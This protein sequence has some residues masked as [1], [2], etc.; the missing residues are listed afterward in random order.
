ML[1]LLCLY[2]CA[3][4]QEVSQRV[5]CEPYGRGP[6]RSVD[7]KLR[8]MLTHALMSPVRNNWVA[9]RCA[10]FSKLQLSRN[11]DGFCPCF[12]S[13]V[14]WRCFSQAQTPISGQRI[15]TQLPPCCLH[16]GVPHKRIGDVIIP[17]FLPTD[18]LF[19]LCKAQLEVVT[20][21]Q[22]GV[23]EVQICQI[24][25]VA[26]CLPGLLLCNKLKTSG[27]SWDVG[28]TLELSPSSDA[29]LVALP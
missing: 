19:D 18:S 29:F 22:A 11:T 4:S 3:T 7:P 12:C 23:G 6:E 20:R 25:G 1:D 17:S 9:T 27:A 15:E 24:S 26:G 5:Y 21:C 8:T 14:V 16:E 10:N 28:C 13:V 2:H